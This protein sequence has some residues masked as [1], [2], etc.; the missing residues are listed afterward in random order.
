VVRHIDQKWSRVNGNCD[1]QVA[2]A[3][4][5]FRLVAVSP[6]VATGSP[7]STGSGRWI[8]SE[9]SVRLG[10]GTVFEGCVQRR[11][12]GKNVLTALDES[13]MS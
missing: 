6:T 12:K 8:R 9:S 10:Q 7:N 2:L 1:W 4:Q 11:A 13:T 3:S 5:L